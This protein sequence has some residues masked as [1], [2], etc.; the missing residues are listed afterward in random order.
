MIPTVEE[1]AKRLCPKCPKCGGQPTV[2]TM[3]HDGSTLYLDKCGSYFGDER[4]NKVKAVPEKVKK[5][6]KKKPKI[7]PNPKLSIVR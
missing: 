5:I 2:A 4:D 3:A 7:D 6:T 1:L